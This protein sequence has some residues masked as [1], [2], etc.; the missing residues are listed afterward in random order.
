MNN[1]V[2][3]NV[4]INLNIYFGG[5]FTNTS[6]TSGSTMN[7]ISYFSSNTIVTPLTITTTTSGFL[8]TETGT[9]SSTITIPTRYKLTNLIYNSSLTAW[10]EAYRSIGVT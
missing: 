9:I 6:P 7:N 3:S 8:D 2:Y 1:P 4:Y 10:L 5:A